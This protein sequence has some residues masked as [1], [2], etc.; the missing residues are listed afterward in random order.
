MSTRNHKSKVKLLPLMLAFQMFVPPQAYGSQNTMSTATKILDTANAI[1]QEYIKQEQMLAQQRQAMAAIQQLNDSLS[2][3]PVDPSQVP[4]ILGQ[5]GCIVLQARSD[6]ASSAISCQGAFDINMMNTGQYDALL[7]VAEQNTNTLENFLTKGH[8]RFTTQGMGCYDKARNQLQASLNGRVQMLEQMKESIEN[9]IQAFNKLA[10]KDIKDLKKG[11]ALLNGPKGSDKQT[12]AA[13][14]DFKWESKFQD[15]QCKSLAQSKFKESGAAGGFR[16]IV[17]S[18]TKN[19][20]AMN[21]ENFFTKQDQYTKEIRMI[22]K[23]AAKQVMREDEIPGATQ[24]LSGIRTSDFSTSAKSLVQSFD[25]AA[26]RARNTKRDMEKNLNKTIGAE[27][28]LAGFAEAIRNDSADINKALMVWEK[29][30]KN[31]CFNEHFKRE[32]GSV[33]GFIKKLED[34][35]ISK[36]AN[37]EADSAF[38]NYVSKILADDTYSVEDKQQKIA[39]KQ[40]QS[41]NSR[42]GLMS[43]RSFT[44]NGKQVGASARLRAKDMV[45]LFANDC[46]QGFDSDTRAGG[47]SG[48]EMV[49]AIKDYA[50]KYANAKKN[51]ANDV[52]KEIIQG[53]IDCPSNTSTGIAANSCGPQSTDINGQGFCVRTANTCASN[54]LSCL[55]KAAKIVETTRK[56]QEAIAKR[57]KGNMDALKLDLIAEFKTVKANFEKSS[58]QIDGLYQFGTT[59]NKDEDP[60]ARQFELNFTTDELYE[61][62]DPSLAIEDPKR[63]REKIVNNINN[64][65][66]QVAEHNTK[67]LAGYDKE[68]KK[69]EDNYK[70]ELASWK[71]TMD[72]CNRKVGQEYSQYMEA[73]NKK[74]MEDSSKQNEKIAQACNKYEDFKVNPCP[75]GRGSEFGDL[76]SDIAAIA[77]TM[78]DRQ[79]ARDIRATVASC[80]SFSNESGV[81]QFFNSGSAPAKKSKYD[82]SLGEF[83][84]D[85]GPGADFDECRVYVKLK[86]GTVGGK[87]SNEDLIAGYEKRKSDY[88]EIDGKVKRIALDGECDGFL[89]DESNLDTLSSAHQKDLFK[90]AGCDSNNSNFKT[91]EK[92]R[93]AALELLSQYKRQG[94]N[95]EVGEIRVAACESGFNGDPGLPDF[96]SSA[97]DLAGTIFGFGASGF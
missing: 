55:E 63:Y 92:S 23:E 5:N 16:G 93:K 89:I 9:R 1:G 10:E 20:D 42:Y 4:P 37:E 33:D 85:K 94:V 72:T 82:I 53:M 54:A 19:R 11:D 31:A 40:A 60:L 29:T 56:E 7:T 21:A 49:D 74:Q 38:K 45:G 46:I 77:T 96:G 30:Q 83:C 2:I 87:C 41:N 35:N 68:I 57:Y 34:P 26:T 66:K 59:Y 17:D 39:E 36:K 28:T 47:S 91:Y 27:K 64:L 22:A 25:V 73:F 14:K 15:N 90:L 58:Q 75:S 70:R 61:G 32:F 65:K 86:N 97:R 43:Q 3:K 18:L 76:A 78:D 69:Y 67:I 81:N 71:A 24:V 88:C 95:S 48:R 13:M 52:Q 8:E 12:Q 62:I 79:A 44:V 80:D 50:N 84:E 51:F 6:Q